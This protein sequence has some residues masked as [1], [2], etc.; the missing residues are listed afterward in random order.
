MITIHLYCV[1]FTSSEQQWTQEIE[2]K[3]LGNILPNKFLHVAGH[4]AQTL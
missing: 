3:S 1:I 2:L 4:R